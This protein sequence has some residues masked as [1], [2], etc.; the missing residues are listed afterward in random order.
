[1]GSSSASESHATLQALGPSLPSDGHGGCLVS[2][3]VP[4]SP[5]GGKVGLG[6]AVL[7]LVEPSSYRQPEVFSAALLGWSHPR[8]ARVWGESWG[9]AGTWHVQGSPGPPLREGPV[10]HCS[11]RSPLSPSRLMNKLQPNSVRKINRSAQNWH[12][13]GAGSPA[14]ALATTEPRLHPL[15]SPAGVLPL[16]SPSSR[17]SPTSSRPWP[18][19]A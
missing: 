7:A 3:G 6:P 16:S 5:Q 13:V 14:C 15:P 17:T 8:S 18:A 1:M 2:P 10:P 4:T 11:P 19:T 12:Q 9:P